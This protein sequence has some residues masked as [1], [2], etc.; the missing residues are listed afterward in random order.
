V[1]VFNTSRS[2]VITPA[3]LNY[4]GHCAAAVIISVMAGF[5]PEVTLGHLYFNTGL[6][7]LVPFMALS[8]FVIGYV[9]NRV[10]GHRAALWVWV[11][12]FTL[13]LFAAYS[14]YREWNPAWEPRGH[15]EYMYV[16]LLGRTTAC[17]GTEC[18][19]ELFFTTPLVTSVMYS[20]AARF[21]LLAYR[22]RRASGVAEP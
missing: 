22:R 12:F 15:L 16:N 2:D 21:G 4:C 13:F 5:V 18:L 6:E 20:V 3:W 7:P 14:L 17:S 1:G 9:M 19:Y 8:A 10:Y 11:P